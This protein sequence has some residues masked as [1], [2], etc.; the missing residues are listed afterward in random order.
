MRECRLR[1]DTEF[2]QGPESLWV[3]EPGLTSGLICH[4]SWRHSD[5]SGRGLL[6]GTSSNIISWG[7][8]C[9]YSALKRNHIL[10]LWKQINLL[11]CIKCVEMRRAL[12]TSASWVTVAWLFLCGGY[13]KE[14]FKLMLQ[15]R[16]LG[17]CF[18]STYSHPELRQFSRVCMNDTLWNTSL[19]L[20]R[21]SS[22][23]SSN[24]SSHS[25]TARVHIYLKPLS[26]S[27]WSFIHWR[28][29]HVLMLERA[30]R[31]YSLF[32]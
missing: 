5:V 2:A 3:A 32:L 10:S 26:M 31:Q 7:S 25:T 17:P 22:I 6:P 14:K 1:K 13:H 8:H 16:L 28:L 30:G 21:V 23:S 19:A 18:V 12:L 20:A 9:K 15:I 29:L 4:Q 24:G 11:D 27:S